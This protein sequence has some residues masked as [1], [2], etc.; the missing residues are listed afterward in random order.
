MMRK[1]PLLVVVASLFLIGTLWMVACEDKINPVSPKWKI[2][3]K[4][5]IVPG[6][7]L[8]NP[9]GSRANVEA[10]AL[11]WDNYWALEL[12]VDLNTGNQ[13]DNI[14]TLGED[15]VFALYISDGSDSIWNGDHLIHLVWM[16]D[17]YAW[18]STSPD[19]VDVFDLAMLNAEIHP[20]LDSPTIDGHGDDD[21]WIVLTDITWETKLE[22]SGVSGDNRLREAY[23]IA[24]HDSSK[25]YFKLAWPDPTSTMSMEKDLW[26]FD[27]HTIWNQE[28]EED[29]VMFLFPMDEAPTDWETLG[30]ATF[31]PQEG[32][33]NGAVNIWMWAAGRTNP[34]GYADDLLATA[35]EL[36]EDQG[37]SGYS[38]NYDPAKSYPPF[39]QDPSVEPT[40]GS[41][42]LLES[43]AIPFEE[44]IR[45]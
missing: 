41:K 32:P 4:G 28:G 34:L 43:E 9:S 36:E 25:L 38:E 39:V 2:W 20:D 5:D 13:D 16:E 27:G 45:P 11:M 7:I 24:V 10:K 22:I 21:I 26:H 15:L 18:P 6:Y 42:V 40:A 8:T 23:I 35:S 37:G 17:L 33:D 44:T 1:L 31:F 14:F 29:I 12:A 30:G 3:K 19:T